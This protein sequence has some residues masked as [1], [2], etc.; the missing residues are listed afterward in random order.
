[1]HYKC[2]NGMK[3]PEEVTGAH[4]E[5]SGLSYW[6]FG[7]RRLSGGPIGRAGLSSGRAGKQSCP[8]H[9]TNRTYWTYS[10]NII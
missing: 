4:L 6:A 10:L 9:G 2:E 5:N 3:S 8:L 7:L 1:M